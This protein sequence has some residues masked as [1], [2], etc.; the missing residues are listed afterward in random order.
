MCGERSTT[1]L[2]VVVAGMMR[3]RDFSLPCDVA[4]SPSEVVQ[5]ESSGRS[6][7]QFSGSAK[8]RDLLK[9]ACERSRWTP[10][11]AGSIQLNSGKP[12]KLDFH[13]LFRRNRQADPAVIAFSL[14]GF[15]DVTY[16]NDKVLVS[17]FSANLETLP[18]AQAHP[19]TAQWWATQLEATAVATVCGLVRQLFRPRR[20]T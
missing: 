2:S 10:S 15:A 18:G 19:K 5:K 16:T 8:T 3:R 7:V 13:R 20:F 6:A 1:T 17:T 11:A 4:G 12:A 9:A 14:I